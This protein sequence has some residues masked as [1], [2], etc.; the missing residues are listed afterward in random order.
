M[1][2]CKQ[3]SHW[4]NLSSLWQG[5]DWFAEISSLLCDHSL[6]S[7]LEEEFTERV[8]EELEEVFDIT[9][10]HL[11]ENKELKIIENEL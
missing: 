1:L 10:D 4:Q 5:L 6:F 11:N 7:F 8:D 3:T 2:W 9:K